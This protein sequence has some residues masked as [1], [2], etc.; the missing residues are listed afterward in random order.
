MLIEPNCSKRQCV[1]FL[2][3]RGDPTP[4]EPE[5]GERNYCAAFPDGIPDEITY[6]SNLHLKPVDGDHG[7]QYEKDGGPDTV[8]P[9]G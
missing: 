9:A 7:L 6:G 1:H 2:G 4:G 8:E 5:R 3:V